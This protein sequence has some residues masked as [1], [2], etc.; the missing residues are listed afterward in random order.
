MDVLLDTHAFIWYIEGTRNLSD[1]AKEIIESSDNK[2]YFSI[3][4]IWEI[5]IKNSK[6]K[7]DLK[8]PFH[9]LEYLLQQLNIDILPIT[10]ADM[11]YNIDLPFH[12]NDPFDRILI[13]Q[14]MNN[15][16]ILLSCDA[17][18]DAYEIRRS[19]S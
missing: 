1:Q 9:E 6:G 8:N 16:L 13:A 15:S 14:A 7:L 12:H 5:A 11:K 10:F 18:F 4:S 17:A 19:W 2:L 3:A